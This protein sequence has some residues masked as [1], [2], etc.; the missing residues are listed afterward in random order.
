MDRSKFRDRDRVI[1]AASFPDDD[2][3]QMS[4]E[5]NK[6]SKTNDIDLRSRTE[7]TTNIENVRN[8]NQLVMDETEG[9]VKLSHRINLLEELDAELQTNT[10]ESHSSSQR[11]SE[12]ASS[13]YSLEFQ[14]HAA[15][16]STRM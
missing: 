15:L 10:D 4:F 1:S 5:N 6:Q 3:Y 9:T 14:D 2:P 11:E 12:S 8:N 16:G 7:A 13:T